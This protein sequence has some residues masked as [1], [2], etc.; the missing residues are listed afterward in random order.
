MDD[1]F[2][3]F[4]PDA[5][6]PRRR[7]F[8]PVPFRMIAPNMITLLALCLGLTAIRLAFEGKFEPAVIAVVVAAVLDGIDGRVARLLKGT[9]R[10]GAELDSLAD[11]VNFGCAPALILYG[12]AL[13]PLRSVGWI[14]AL[15]FAIAMALRLAR[16]NAMLDDP[17]RP[18]WKKD[19]FV[20]M[21]APAG[22]LTAMLPLYL[23]FLGLTFESWAA[24]LV[25]AYV[26]GIAL[27]VVSTVPTFSGKT[28]GKRVPREFVLP[29]FL[30]IVVVFGLV[31]SFPFET[32][33]T[34][35]VA[36]LAAL[37][38]GAVQYRRRQK[39]EPALPAPDEAHETAA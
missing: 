29:I 26:L 31:I 3:P 21:P 36:Y 17:S 2:P 6:E 18:E 7:R 25:L 33:V 9:S 35:A 20:G 24:P 1:L 11:F 4:E 13:N 10:F 38:V 5:N 27:L 34:L 22:A 37:P 12:F 30:V 32:M 39:Q 8:R 16:F 15:V 23:H 28:W 14:V 19:F